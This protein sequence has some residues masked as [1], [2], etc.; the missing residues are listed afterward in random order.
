MAFTAE[1]AREAGKKSSRE[2][3]PNK[4]TAELRERIKNV[5]EENFERLQEDINQL[6]PKDRVKVIL[7]LAKFVIPTLKSTE[8]KTEDNFT[9]IKIINLGN[10]IC[11]DQ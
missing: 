2:G 9:P 3:T 6:E 1:T 4:T 11:P 10:G 5:L 8:L 7:D